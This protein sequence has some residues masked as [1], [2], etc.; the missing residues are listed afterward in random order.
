MLPFLQFHTDLPTR[1]NMKQQGFGQSYA[2]IQHV[3]NHAAFHL[4]LA[5][6]IAEDKSKILTK[7]TSKIVPT[8]LA[9]K[10]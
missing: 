9:L 10:L 6:Y 8:E 3:F 2:T 1:F 5:I 7:I 4:F